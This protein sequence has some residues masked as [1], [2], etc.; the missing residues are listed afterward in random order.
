MIRLGEPGPY[1]GVKLLPPLD[2][3]SF[4][5]TDTAGAP[6]E[7][8]SATKGALT[9]LFFGYTHCPDVCP[10]TM[11]NI[12]AGLRTLEP[13]LRERTKVVFVTTDPRRD[14][15]PE[16]R[17]WLDQFDKDFIGL[18]GEQAAINQVMESLRLRDPIGSEVTDAGYTVA[19]ASEVIAFTQDDMGHLIYPEG[20][21]PAD[22]AHDL[23]K[24]AKDGWQGKDIK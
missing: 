12:A 24:L 4:S 2:R 8:G 10:T 9:L 1:V 22:F 14:T 7:F 18:T 15:P 5:L 21:P 3:P 13:A 16:L 17:S 11:S 20:A 23:A 19:H 6:F